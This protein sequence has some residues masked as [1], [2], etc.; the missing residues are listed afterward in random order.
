MSRAALMCKETYHENEAMEYYCKECNVCICHKC[1]Q[2][3][4]NQHDKMDIQHAGEEQK[5]HVTRT[6]ERAKAQLNVVENMMKK[7]TELMKKSE[8]E[9][10]TAERDV[11]EYVN[12]MVQR[13]REQETAIKTELATVKNSQQGYYQNNMENLQ[14]F[15][16]QLRGSVE[17]CEG[18]LQ[19]N[20]CHEILKAGHAVLSHCEELLNTHQEIELYKPQHVTF[21]GSGHE[22]S[23]IGQ[24]VVSH[25][26]PSQSVAEG[27]GLK[28]A[29]LGA[30]T[31]FTVTTRDSDGIQFYNDE[32]QV[33]VKIC[34]PTNE[35][36]V[37]DIQ[38]FEDGN[39]T[40]YHRPKSLGLHDVS[41]K[42]NGRQLTGS[43]WS[44]P[45][46]PH[47]YRS[48]R[49]LKS[50][51]ARWAE[52]NQ[53]LSVAV[54]KRSGNIAIADKDNK[55]VHL[56]NSEEKYLGSIGDKWTRSKRMN[57]PRSVAFTASGN[58]IVIHGDVSEKFKMSIF[59]ERGQFVKQI[60]EHLIDPI[61]VFGRNDGNIITCDFGDD[62]VKVLSPGGTELLRSFGAPYCDDHEF[63][64]FAVSDQD[65]FFVSYREAHC[66]KVFNK[67]GVFLYDIGSKGSGDGQL[68]FPEDIVIDKFNNLIVCDKANNR[69]QVFALDGKYLNSVNEM[70]LPNSVAVTKDGDLLVC[71][72]DCVQVF[73]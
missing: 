53:P 60:R 37:K 66:I 21:V 64:P 33:D 29:E 47:Q 72:G 65:K 8:E 9:I 62:T 56:F 26:D 19:R 6:V 61:A 2:T 34:S 31:T 18:V 1:G 55:R 59:T 69:L 23:Q 17:Y 63:P 73:H 67:E 14:L 30:E 25:T 38:E 20:I 3:R 58:V 51:G 28:E 71:T 41:V 39:Y 36:E 12:K 40:V 52:F 35:D 7:Q 44:V 50:C 54:S 42:V 48:L 70:E 32:D 57:Q 16:T 5:I 27:K 13:L 49:S 11:T 4:H 24:V 45:V 68:S 15:A 46:T 22:L 43:P 10:L